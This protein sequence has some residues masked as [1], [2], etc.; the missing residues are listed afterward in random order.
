MRKRERKSESFNQKHVNDFKFIS[1]H[2][3]F[4]SHLN[5]NSFFETSFTIN[6]LYT[7]NRKRQYDFENLIILWT[8]KTIWFKK[9]QFMKKQS[10]FDVSNFCY[11]FSFYVRYFIWF[12]NCKRNHSRSNHISTK[13]T[14]KQTIKLKETNLLSLMKNKINKN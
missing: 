7:L 9:K 5:L 12:D 2:L 13:A 14:S 1:I 3:I 11:F 6:L 4:T 8:I 10:W